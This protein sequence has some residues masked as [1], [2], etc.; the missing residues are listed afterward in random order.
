MKF[1]EKTQKPIVQSSVLFSSILVQLKYT[2]NGFGISW[3][4]KIR[5]LSIFIARSM[6]F[7]CNLHH[8]KRSFYFYC[9]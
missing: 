3:V 8:A 4:N 2:R 7:N 9:A 1:S 5:Y 6:K